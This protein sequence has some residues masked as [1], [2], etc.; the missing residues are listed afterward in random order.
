MQN[1]IDTLVERKKPKSMEEKFE[2]LR[3]DNP[4]LTVL[5]E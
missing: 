5:S 3:T 2:K 4:S 1:L